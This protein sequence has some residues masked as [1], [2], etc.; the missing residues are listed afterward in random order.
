[1]TLARRFLAV[2]LIWSCSLLMLGGPADAHVIKPVSAERC[3]ANWRIPSE[4]IRQA[5]CFASFF[6]LN[7]DVAESIVVCESGGRYDPPG[8]HEGAWQYN[9][10]TWDGIKAHYLPKVKNPLATNGRHANIVTMRY[11]RHNIAEGDANPW[12]PWSCS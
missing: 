8:F 5:R 1:M 6:G 9:P 4:L 12:H 11:V 2:A 10:A 3:Q 7:P